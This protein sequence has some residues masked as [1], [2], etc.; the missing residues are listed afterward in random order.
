MTK[1]AKLA[2]SP[3]EQTKAVR[4]RSASNSQEQSWEVEASTVMDYAENRAR[5][6]LE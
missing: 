1:D 4:N 3:T 2:A 5:T 6:R